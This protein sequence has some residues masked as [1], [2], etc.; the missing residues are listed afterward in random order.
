MTDVRIRRVDRSGFDDLARLFEGHGNPGYCW[1]MLWR[2]PTAAYRGTDSAGRRGML[3]DRVESGEP[4]GLLA[5]DGDRPIGWC[6]IAP[7]ETYARI[8][9]SRLRRRLDDR[10]TWSVVCFVIE[11]HHRHA[12]VRERLL[13]AAC[14]DAAGH[15]AEVVEA[16]P[17]PEG[18]PSYRFMGSRRFWREAGFAP[19]P[20]N[21][22]IW[23]R[24]LAPAS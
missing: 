4:V 7:R 9:R 13:E 16:Y 19:D 24:E 15:G 2:V 6:S 8:E 20:R 22:R 10:P 11:R 12:G 3:R 17:A 18:G 5:Y 21:D 1:C 23:R 14:A